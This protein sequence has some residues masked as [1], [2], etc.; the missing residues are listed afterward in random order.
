MLP[1]LS[2]FEEYGPLKIMINTDNVASVGFSTPFCDYEVDDYQ[3]FHKRLVQVLKQL[4]PSI[5]V[6]V[7]L[8]SNNRN[9]LNQEIPR[10]KSINEIGFVQNEARIFLSAHPPVFN[11]FRR[12]SF[13]GSSFE[14]LKSAYESFKSL[15]I[16]LEPINEAEL[17]KR[18]PS[19][20][21][22]GERSLEGATDS[23]GVV[24]IL[25]NP[26][27][28]FNFHDL[29][30]ALSNL[31]KPFKYIVSFKRI[32]EA[33]AKVL[34]ERKSKQLEGARKVEERL[35]QASMED[36][37]SDAFTSG[38]QL[39]EIETL[40]V[41][42]RDSQK[43]LSRDLRTSQSALSLYSESMIETFG[44]L[45]SFAASLPGSRLHVPLLENEDALVQS[46]PLFRTASPQGKENTNRALTLHRSDNS[47]FH[48]DLF[49]PLF[50]SFN[51]LIVGPT[52]K[53]KSVLT[54]LLTTSVLNSPEVH[55]IKIDVG[56]SHSKE[57][58]LL[59][60]EEFVFELNQPSNINPFKSLTKHN[61]SAP[62]RIAIVSKFLSVLVQEIGEKNLTKEMRGEIE[63]S[64]RIYLES[65]PVKPSLNDFV[66]NSPGFPRIGLLKRWAKG[67]VYEYA[68]AET[69]K[70]SSGARL[71][72]FNFK[73][74]FQAADP[75]FA[76]A[77]FAALMAEMNAQVLANDGRRLVLILDE[78]P[79]FIKHCFELIKFTTANFRKYGHAV[80]P[81][82]Q[83]MDHLIVEEDLGIVENIFQ[84]F[85]FGDEGAAVI[86]ATSEEHLALLT[87]LQSIPGQYSE[88]ALQTEAGMRKLVIKLS[89]EE[90]WE[91]TSS[92]T[93]KQRMMALMSAVPGLS[94]R[95]AITCLSL[96]R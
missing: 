63:N 45:P 92:K 74:I 71:Q 86:G 81:I 4:D 39:F 23:T 3:S 66:V 67:G 61:A 95:Q 36:A 18:I 5:I 37:Q 47:L 20:F 9:D 41:L 64:V 93:D 1:I 88:A 12:K 52:G 19:D 34:L 46:L 6:R 54:G 78:I 56:G 69:G 70:E 2:H 16:Q 48:F 91:R 72:Y 75:E 17:V 68:F 73:N 27:A 25:K 21:V 24:R 89:R 7:N 43:E 44:L 26:R 33:E 50:N 94:L 85:L 58:E 13:S 11:F 77:G 80:I 14:I 29:N 57:C 90:Y 62:E 87:G 49:N 84:R 31:P 30:K 8:E 83:L 96:G 55:V 65:M 15:G 42:T 35:Q 28:E 53:G 38:M 59:G 82:S 76:V 79:F 51:A 10:S 60:G 40:L 22:I 32:G